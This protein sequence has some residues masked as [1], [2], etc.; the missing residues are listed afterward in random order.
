MNKP[1]LSVRDLHVSYGAINAVS[2]ISFELFKGEI[3]AIVGS[4]GA[5]KTT[6]L[7]AIS[8]LEKVK[9]GSIKLGDQELV[10]LPPHKIVEVGVAH[11][12]EGRRS[13]TAM[14]VLENLELG[15][16]LEKN[17]LVIKERL[18]KVF[19]TFPRLAERKNQVAG[20]L[21]GGEQ[22]MLAVGRALMTQGKILLMDEPSMGLAPIIVEEIFKIIQTLNKMGTSILL[23]EQNAFLALH[24]AKRAYVFETGKVRISGN[25]EELLSNPL[26][27]EAYL[28]A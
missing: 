8:G 5:G 14:T 6:T 28:G 3:V 15:A 22:Q 26:V 18:E 25:S 9:S 7:R 12:P 19:D 4:N 16:N 23:I 10:G 17:P 27:R 1:L 11:V 13:F 21:S 2:G 20:T 24:T